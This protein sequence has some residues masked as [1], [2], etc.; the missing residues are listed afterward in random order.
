MDKDLI[1]EMRWRQVVE[2]EAAKK[3]F[4]YPWNIK[5]TEG[6]NSAAKF[7]YTYEQ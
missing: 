4:E 6:Y 2:Q 5:F 3:N 7:T 1:S